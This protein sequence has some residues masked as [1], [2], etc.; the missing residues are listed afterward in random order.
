MRLS[1]AVLHLRARG[2]ASLAVV[3]GV[4]FLVEVTG[5]HREVLLPFSREEVLDLS[6]MV[7][8]ALAVCA[9]VLCTPRQFEL[10]QDGERERCARLSA[11]GL[12]MAAGVA[13]LALATLREPAELALAM[14]NFCCFFGLVLLVGAWVEA[15]LAALC[16]GIFVL[17]YGYLGSFTDGTPREWAWLLQAPKSVPAA[18]LSASCWAVGMTVDVARSRSTWGT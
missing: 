1:C 8:Y 16:V 18:A 3:A 11:L 13:L 6:P 9:A 5:V 10:E 14:R 17:L 4:G 7:P 12:V 2:I 15:R